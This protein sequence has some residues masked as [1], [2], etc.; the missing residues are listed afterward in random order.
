M[1]ITSE[2]PDFARVV[3]YLDVLFTEKMGLEPPCVHERLS[4][5][6]VQTGRALS[7]RRDSV[8]RYETATVV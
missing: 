4:D 3:G 8:R 1:G 2:I 7:V 6:I 5:K